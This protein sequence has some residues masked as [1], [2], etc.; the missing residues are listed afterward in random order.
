LTGMLTNPKD[1]LPFHML[2]A[3]IPALPAEL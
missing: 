3:A 1:M 2:L